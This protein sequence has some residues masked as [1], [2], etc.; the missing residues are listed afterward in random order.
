MDFSTELCPCF[1]DGLERVG[2]ALAG[3][4]GWWTFMKLLEDFP[5]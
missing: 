4:F 5:E 3:M 1:C 2:R